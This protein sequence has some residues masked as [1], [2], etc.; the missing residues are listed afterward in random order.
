MRTFCRIIGIIRRNITKFRHQ[1]GG[2]HKNAYSTC[3]TTLN[4]ICEKG[5]P[6]SLTGPYVRGDYNT[7]KLHTNALQDFEPSIAMAYSSIALASLRIAKE[8]GSMSEAEYN[9]SLIHI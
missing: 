2:L 5:L 9:L 3:E 1:K 6:K 8:Q 4:E 7:V